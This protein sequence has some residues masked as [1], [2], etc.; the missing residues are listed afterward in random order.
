MFVK[1]EIQLGT[2]GQVPVIPREAVVH[3]E[4]GAKVFVISGNKATVRNIR[5][6]FQNDSFIEVTQGLNE[7]DVIA[8]MGMNNL[9]AGSDVVISEEK[10]LTTG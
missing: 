4:E 10:D 9:K 7:N 2:D 1:A 3:E 5:L 8:R 6:G